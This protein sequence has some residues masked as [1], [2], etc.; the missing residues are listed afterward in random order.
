MGA[1][2]WRQWAGVL[3]CWAALLRGSSGV[4]PADPAFDLS[5]LRPTDEEELPP[6]SKGGKAGAKGGKAKPAPAPEPVDPAKKVGLVLEQ[7]VCNLR[8]ESNL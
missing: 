7:L 3:T 2:G 4:I 8:A 5:L 6:P 1:R